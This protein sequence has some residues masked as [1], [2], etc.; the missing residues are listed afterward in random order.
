MM[1]IRTTLLT[2]LLAVLT[3][4]FQ[5]APPVEP[6]RVMAP[7]NIGA[8]ARDQM[9]NPDYMMRLR[10]PG[11]GAALGTGEAWRYWLDV[12][13]HDWNG[14]RGRM[15]ETTFD[16]RYGATLEVRLFAPPERGNYPGLVFT[17]GYGAAGASPAYWSLLQRI[18][19]EGYVVA[20][21]SP[22]GTGGSD[23]DPDPE[24]CGGDGSEWW[25]QPQEAGLVESNECAGH[26]GFPFENDPTG[27]IL[28]A[29]GA[30][31]SGEE[32]YHAY[33]DAAYA[34]F[35]P[36]Y[37]F[38]TIDTAHWLVSSDNPLRTEVKRSRIGAFG[39]SAGADAATLSAAADALIDAAV[40]LDGWGDAVPFAATGG[41]TL[42]VGGAH[43]LPGYDAQPGRHRA[44]DHA[45]AYRD[46]AVPT[47]VVL[48]DDA[49]HNDF[50]YIPWPFSAEASN[51]PYTRSVAHHY[52]LAW[53]DLHLQR[54]RTAAERLTAEV[55][56]G[57]ADRSSIG[58]GTYDP[59]TMS[60]VPYRIEGRPVSDFTGR[61]APNAFWLP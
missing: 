37:V 45:E 46:A 51:Q 33:L 15:L 34:S 31:A 20:A 49:V 47:G 6:E 4:G 17:P 22:Q 53:F 40:A 13:R 55:F 43:Q 25:R 14:A 42:F 9:L 26:H 12:Y 21:V 44:L 59:L 57:S 32:E 60:N 48:I 2:A 23:V 7:Q 41:P 18:A 1:R 19:E 38:A 28:T 58:Q 24:Y 61:R 27:N 56:D 30:M 54:D 5:P 36:A 8:T 52:L 3:V 10:E 35:R 50:A 11:I 16:N 29:V 39:H